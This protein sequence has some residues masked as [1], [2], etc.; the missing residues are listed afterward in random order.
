VGAIAVGAIAVAAIAATPA[1]AADPATATVRVEGLSETKLPP[2]Q[3]T[4]NTEKV[5]K[6]GDQEDSCS[7]TS[8]LGA[9][10][11]A[12]GGNW[13]GP[14]NSEYRDYEIYSIEGENHPFESGSEANYYWDFWLNDKESGVGACGVEL[15][16]GDQVLFFVACYGAKCP[17]EQSP[18]G[19]EA[20]ASANVGEPI[21][22]IVKQY[23]SG[24]EPSPAIAATITGGGASVTTDKTGH[25]TLTFSNAGSYLLHVSGSSTGPP[26]VRTETYICVHN[27]NDGTC[28]TSGPSGSGISSGS[29]SSGAGAPTAPYT[30]PYAVV[31]RVTAL[32]EH[33]RYSGADAPRILSGTVSAPVGVK[34][35]ELR[36]T[37]TAAS[38]SGARRCSY[39]DGRTDR[40]QA[41]RCGAD[42][43]RFFSIGDDANFS[44]LLP[45]K[46]PAGRYVLDIEATDLAGSQTTLARGSSRVVFYVA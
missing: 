8:A 41:M 42:H 24:G 25:A 4:T 29:P 13:S 7:G 3:V 16:P 27:G 19:I 34:D 1:L 28:G 33:H 36:L 35:V 20:P 10:Q 43:G 6:D 44:Y 46:L 40:F 5:V 12:T 9:L 14:W 18:L 39:Y 26:A 38:S 17:P 30:G 15:E 45:A 21:N 11:L 23:N 22:V 31:A 2:T 37:R 32:L